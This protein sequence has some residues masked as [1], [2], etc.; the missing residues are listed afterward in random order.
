M[1]TIVTVKEKSQT[2]KTQAMSKTNLHKQVQQTLLKDSSYRS[3][4]Y[5]PPEQ[6][7][8]IAFEMYEHFDEA[9]RI[10]IQFITCFNVVYK[11]LDGLTD[12]AKSQHLFGDGSLNPENK[13]KKQ[14]LNEFTVALEKCANDQGHWSEVWSML[15]DLH[16]SGD[17]RDVCLLNLMEQVDKIHKTDA[18]VVKII[19]SIKDK[20][21]QKAIMRVL[22]KNRAGGKWVYHIS[23]P[24]KQSAAKRE[25]KKYAMIRANNVTDCETI[26]SK[27]I[28]VEKLLSKAKEKSDILIST[29]ISLVIKQVGL[30][31]PE[32]EQYHDYVHEG[33][34][35]MAKATK[36]YNPYNEKKTQ[37]H[38]YV[39]YQVA[40]SVSLYHSR[41]HNMIISKRPAIRNLEQI[42]GHIE[43][44]RKEGSP[45]DL[46]EYLECKTGHKRSEI[47]NIINC[48]VTAVCD[49]MMV[50][51]AED[52]YYTLP[53][54]LYEQ[55]FN[56][57]K[58]RKMYLEQLTET[59]RTIFD[60]R[61]K[62]GLREPVP[63]RKFREVTN[64]NLSHGRVRQIEN[65]IKAR[66]QNIIEN[67]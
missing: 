61:I 24:K 10:V 29:N 53:D 31:K 32:P 6:Q 19:S 25:L 40:E 23:D 67:G 64:V 62:D 45:G 12:E 63:Y 28:Q 43:A 36:R 1:V 39:Y 51:H 58:I 34:V 3:A 5:L 11:F 44:Y 20:N 13:S 15:T 49:Q 55:D 48:D 35:G 46:M 54:E 8:E 60:C 50:E 66:I 52:E 2:A 27:A 41:N 42:K 65:D 16:I 22:K 4:K 18:N 37:Y 47:N 56:Q 21:E 59:E 7:R 26:L 33:I 14:L 57:R 38:S 17:L 9:K 30:K